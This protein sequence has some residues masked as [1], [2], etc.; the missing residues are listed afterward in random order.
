[1]LASSPS[2]V[3]AEMCNFVALTTPK[4]VLYHTVYSQC[5]SNVC[6]PS[7]GHNVCRLRPR[8]A[9]PS[10]AVDTFAWQVSLV[11]LA[12]TET[13]VLA[14]QARSVTLSHGFCFRAKEI[15]RVDPNLENMILVAYPFFT[16]IIPRSRLSATLHSYTQRQPRLSSPEV[17]P[18]ST[19][20]RQQRTREACHQQARLRVW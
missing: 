18:C 20:Y 10:L 11:L 2:L 14:C 6:F 9:C 19:H 4:Q 7:S 16:T 3:L 1:M 17:T 13:F 15:L 5:H 12:A 8:Y